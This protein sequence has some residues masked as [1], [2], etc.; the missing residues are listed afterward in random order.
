[1]AGETIHH[2]RAVCAAVAVDLGVPDIDVSTVTGPLRLI[3]QT[4]AR[5][6]YEQV[7]D[8]GRPVHAGIRYMSRLNPAWECW[9]VF[10]DRMAHA[11]DP[12][13]EPIRIDDP[14]LVESACLLDLLI[15]GAS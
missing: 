5:Y 2:L 4:A 6:F 14:G 10:H 7:D 9:A 12:V 11:P 15:E 8:A 3:T 13:V 1:M